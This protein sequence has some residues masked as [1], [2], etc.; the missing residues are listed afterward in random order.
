MSSRQY[1]TEAALL[2]APGR[3]GVDEVA[4]DGPDDGQV[5]VRMGAAGVCHT[6]KHLHD[7]DDGWGRPFP[8]LLG[9]EGAG[10]VEAVGAAVDGIEVGD[11]VAVGCR[12]PCGRCA[13]CR[14]GHTRIC[15]SS[16]A[17]MP[18][19]ER[20]AD[21]QAVL[22]PMGIGLFA[23]LVPVDARAAV[24][25]ERDIPM[26]VLGLLGCAVMTGVGAVLNTARVWP[27]ARVAVIG[28]G[29]IGLSAV[30]GARAAHA[31]QVIAVDLADRKLEWARKLGATDTVNAAEQDVVDAVRS[32]TGGVGVDFSFEAVGNP[33][34]VEQCIGMLAY[35]G[36]ATIVGKPQ[37][38]SFFSVNLG[39][40]TRGFFENTNTLTV[41]HGGDGL[42]AFDLP[43]YAQMHR[44]GRLDLDGLVT[45][46]VSLSGLGEGF[47]RMESGDAIRT[48]VRFD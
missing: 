40:S 48:V 28:C 36:M 5:L 38:E 41:T 18:S 10:V 26:G 6:D 35:G 47:D 34:C 9:H 44:Q 30:Q 17:R 12:V 33:R 3:L 39:G 13:Q 23:R 7:S 45:H 37:G 4:F 42:P 46:E 27:G 29:G 11:H 31:R 43:L 25:M 14:R 2:E 21:G 20:A 8:M 19:I 32:L 1:V 15:Q 16:S 22:S 24:V